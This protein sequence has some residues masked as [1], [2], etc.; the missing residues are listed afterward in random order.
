MHLIASVKT[1]VICLFGATNPK[2]WQ[3]WSDN[4]KIIISK[5]N[6]SCRP[7][8]CKKTCFNSEKNKCMFTI[9]VQDIL[10]EILLLGRSY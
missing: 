8:H 6:I 4:A 1:P 9:Q 3:P 7:C 10:D 2:R 5:E